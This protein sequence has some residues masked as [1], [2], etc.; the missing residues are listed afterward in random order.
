MVLPQRLP[1]GNTFITPSTMASV[2]ALQDVKVAIAFVNTQEFLTPLPS[3]PVGIW[4][5]TQAHH[6]LEV[7]DGARFA[8]LL[9]VDLGKMLGFECDYVEVAVCL[10]GF[11]VAHHYIPLPELAA[12][13]GEF[14]IKT[15]VDGMSGYAKTAEFRVLT[16]GMT[17]DLAF[18]NRVWQLTKNRGEY[19]RRG[20]EHSATCSADRQNPDRCSPCERNSCQIQQ[21]RTQLSSPRQRLL[22]QH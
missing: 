4:T 1:F 11:E 22:R 10:D 9:T 12:N 17:N 20:R 2:W 6:T 3:T 18:S 19:S 15:F 8:V 14:V 7:R 16:T 13:R 21:R 5:P